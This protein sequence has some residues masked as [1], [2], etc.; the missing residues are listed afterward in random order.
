MAFTKVGLPGGLGNIGIG[1][2]L[3]Y[4]NVLGTIH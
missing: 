3:E 2:L 4:V 1:D